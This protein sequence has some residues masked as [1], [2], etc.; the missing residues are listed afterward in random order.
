MTV[1]ITNE[2]DVTLYLGPLMQGCS[3]A[4]FQVADA[5]GAAL[6]SPGYYCGTCQDVVAGNIHPCLCP[7]N[8]A[9]TLQ[10]GESVSEQW[11]ASFLETRTLPNEC[12]PEL[13]SAQCSQ[14]VSVTPGVFTF[15]A[16]ASTSLDCSGFD[17][18]PCPPCT[19]QPNG[20]CFTFGGLLKGA[21]RTAQTTV[22][23]DA[24]Y[25]VGESDSADTG[26]H[27][28]TRAVVISFTN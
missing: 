24:S 16:Q 15:S 23:L 13:L 12:A 28:P 25:G 5:T 8:V 10:P 7:A 2:T 1:N 17:Q 20:E 27:G 26:N 19:P 22:M 3:G 11:S 21:L 14:L 18:D 4:N 6:S 9:I